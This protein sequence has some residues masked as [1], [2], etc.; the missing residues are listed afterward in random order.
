MGAVKVDIAKGSR[1]YTQKYA[2][3]DAKGVA[4]LLRDRHKI[5]SRRFYAGDYAASDILIDLDNAIWKAFLTNRQAE[6]IAYVYGLD[7]TQETAAEAMGV[8]QDS[9]SDFIRGACK[10]IARVYRKW[11]SEDGADA[12]EITVTYTEGDGDSETNADSA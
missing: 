10:R 6:A 3:N 5:A 1:N 12:Y 2:L 4:M 11:A 7:V 9:V 8:G